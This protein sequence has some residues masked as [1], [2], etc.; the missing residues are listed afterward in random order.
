VATES[1]KAVYAEL[2]RDSRIA[3]SSLSSSTRE[4]IRIHGRV[5]EL[6][7]RAAKEKAFVVSPYLTKFYKDADDPVMKLFWIEG[8]AEFFQGDPTAASFKTI[9]L[10]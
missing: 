2:A 8:N 6:H 3:I 9:A 10:A 5:H 7:D 4:W 1:Q